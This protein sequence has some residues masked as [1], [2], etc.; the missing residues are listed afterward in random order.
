M[1]KVANPMDMVAFNRKQQRSKFVPPVGGGKK[2]AVVI[3]NDEE[4]EVQC[5]FIFGNALSL[6][7]RVYTGFCWATY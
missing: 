6:T 5:L 3:K 1:D 7:I 4:G 2:T